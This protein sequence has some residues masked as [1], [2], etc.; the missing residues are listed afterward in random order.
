[1][2][3]CASHDTF[4]QMTR[5]S[6]K[7]SGPLHRKIG[8]VEIWSEYPGGAT[9]AAR[10]G[11]VREPRQV[12]LLLRALKYRRRRV[13][14]SRTHRTALARKVGA[15]LLQDGMG[16]IDEPACARAGVPTL[17][18]AHGMAKRGASTHAAA[19]GTAYATLP[20]NARRDVAAPR[21][22][23]HALMVSGGHAKSPGGKPGLICVPLEACGIE[24][25]IRTCSSGRP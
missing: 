19:A 14:R 2:I 3:D 6:L 21:A 9:A 15:N 20:T 22:G 7:D 10:S 18:N 1:M 4:F 17:A 24:K 12:R 13:W 5:G 23:R 16:A 8:P 11:R 25:R